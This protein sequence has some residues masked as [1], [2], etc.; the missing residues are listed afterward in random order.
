M[1]TVAKSPPRA[2]ARPAAQRRIQ[3][4]PEQFR[5]KLRTEISAFLAPNWEVTENR[6]QPFSLKMNFIF[7]IA[8]AILTGHAAKPHR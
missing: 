2:G 8:D 4:E 7:K 3:E 6:Q 5:P 1:R